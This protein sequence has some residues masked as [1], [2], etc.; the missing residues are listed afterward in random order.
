M[1]RGKKRPNQYI[2]SLCLKQKYILNRENKAKERTNSTDTQTH[3]QKIESEVK[4]FFNL[5]FFYFV[6]VKR[7]NE[8]FKQEVFDIGG[9]INNNNNDDD[10]EETHA[11]HTG[12]SI[13][14]M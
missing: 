9:H 3:T 14:R 4:L 1:D 13:K 10:H 2:H 5:P 8:H 12:K 11:Q 6:Y 7:L